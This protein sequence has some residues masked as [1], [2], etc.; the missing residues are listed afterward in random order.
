[1]PQVDWAT[2]AAMCAVLTTGGGAALLVLRSQLSHYFV[3][4]AE[5]VDMDQRM[6]LAERKLASMPNADDFRK[7]MDR[8]AE[9]Q[10]KFDTLAARMDG[11]ASSIGRVESQVDI[12]VRAGLEKEKTH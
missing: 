2:I 3:T 8:L 12:L 6:T 10:G 5:H 1:M 4:R 11:I 7:I 9:G